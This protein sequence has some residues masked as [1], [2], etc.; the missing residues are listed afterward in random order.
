MKHHICL[1]PK[2]HNGIKKTYESMHVAIL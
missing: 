1:H 2:I